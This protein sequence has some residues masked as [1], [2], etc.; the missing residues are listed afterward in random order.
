MPDRQTVA[1][2][3]RVS[4]EDAGRRLTV[5]QQLDT[6]R[7]WS[8]VAEVE[9]AAT[10]RDDGV[11]GKVPFDQR[12]GGAALIAD[13]ELGRFGSVAVVYIDRFGRTLLDGL[14]VAKRLDEIGVGI[15]AVNEGIDSRGNSDPLSLQLRLMIA[16]Q[17][18]RRVVERMTT[19]KRAAMDRDGAP[20]GGTVPFGYLVGQ[21]GELIID[22]REA[23]VVVGVFERALEGQTLTHILEWVKAQGVP[24]GRK[25]MRRGAESATRVR[26]HEKVDWTVGKLSKMLSNPVYAGTRRWGER[27]FECLPLVSREVFERVQQVRREIS[28]RR[29]KQGD[30]AK[31]LLGGLLVCELCGERLYHWAPSPRGVT[32]R[33]Y[34]C[35]GVRTH[36]CPSKLLPLDELDALVWQDVET[37]LRDPGELLYRLSDVDA[38]ISETVGGLE[39]QETVLLR[40]IDGIDTRV[41]ELFAEARQCDWPLSFISPQINHFKAERNRIE[42]E[43]S[44]L[45]QKKSRLSQER[46]S[47]G[48]IATLLAEV[49][50]EL[51]AGLPL[52]ARY[53]V[54]RLV[55]AGGTVATIGSGRDKRGQVRI[56]YRFP[57]PLLEVGVS[58]EGSTATP[59]LHTVNVPRSLPRE[60]IVMQLSQ[61]VL[62]FAHSGSVR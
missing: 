37:W 53:A 29:G 59:T 57:A 41:R 52:D 54:V 8:Q 30:P 20:P 39:D 32:Y 11:S 3:V 25:T 9:V 42:L 4:R 23:A 50:G 51:D 47:A 61:R 17:D 27:T 14:L 40:E 24:S 7:K 35:N 21:R 10:Y 13:A 45:R 16:E 18:H 55:V 62:V 48:E 44:N 34:A 15:I 6:L 1:F 19:G 56:V 22:P 36:R 31:G 28:P 5:E 26:G 58:G 2:Y 33:Y 60:L 38:D 46:S 49:R 12:P 43:L